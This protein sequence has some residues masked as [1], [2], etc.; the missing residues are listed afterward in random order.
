MLPRMKFRNP[1]V[2]MT[3]AKH[4]NPDGPSLLHIYT[5]SP[6]SDTAPPS[7]P[8]V[9]DAQP[10][11]TL[12]I[13]NKDESEILDALIKTLNPEILQPTEHEVELMAEHAA[14]KEQ[15]E[16]DRVEVREKLVKERREA[17]LLK[18]ARG[19]GAAA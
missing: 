6:S 9:P 10:T 18:I 11:H 14:Q 8:P 12:N 13:R 4:T 1:S 5:A 7:S 16:R 17:E 15:S 19:E 2:P 3:V